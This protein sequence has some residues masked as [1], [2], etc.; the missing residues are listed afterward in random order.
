VEEKHQQAKADGKNASK[1][2]TRMAVG[3]MVANGFWVLHFFVVKMF[4]GNPGRR[5]P[6]VENAPLPWWSI[7][8][9]RRERTKP[10]V[11]TS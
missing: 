11:Y 6:V 1:K 2:S 5:H 8:W 7:G 3:D 4:S 10:R 9:Q